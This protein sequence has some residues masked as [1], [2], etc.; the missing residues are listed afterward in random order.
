VT[1][2]TSVH[3]SII[4]EPSTTIIMV[5]AMDEAVGLSGILVSVCQLCAITSQKTTVLVCVQF[6]AVI[7]IIKTQEYRLGYPRQWLALPSGILG[8]VMNRL[9]SLYLKFA[10]LLTWLPS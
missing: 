2:Y 7:L 8:I 5:E 9:S 4:E 1:P 6:G 10:L 3:I